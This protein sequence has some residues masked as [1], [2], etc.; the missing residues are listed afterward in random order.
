MNKHRGF[1]LIELLIVIG[2]IGILATFI[3]AFLGSARNKSRDSLIQSELKSLQS[4]VAITVD[5]GSYADVFTNGDEWVSSYPKIQELL[6]SIAGQTAVHVAGSSTNAWA[7]QAQ[8]ATDATKY[9]CVDA[10]G[11]V[12]IST[13]QINAGDTVCP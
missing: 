1:T 5:S 4:Q 11:V 12:T 13:T 9:F 2:I 6:T 8:A 3:S 10:A 7:A